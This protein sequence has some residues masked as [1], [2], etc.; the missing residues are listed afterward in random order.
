MILYHTIYIVTKLSSWVI[1]VGE[2]EQ[3]TSEFVRARRLQKGLPPLDL[4]TIKD[5][6][7]Y[8][9]ATSKGRL[10]DKKRVTVASINIFAEWFFTGFA[11]VTGNG[12]D[13]EDKGA[14]YHVSTCRNRNYYLRS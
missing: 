7:R 14:V 12:I 8:I 11:R 4:A 13:K 3:D 10:D 9:T 6:L 1:A 5:F 2:R